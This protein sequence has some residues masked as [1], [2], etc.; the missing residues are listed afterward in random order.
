[1]EISPDGTIQALLQ[2]PGVFMI[3]EKSPLGTQEPSADS[4]VADGESRAELSGMSWSKPGLGEGGE[5][6]MRNHRGESVSVGLGPWEERQW[7]IPS[8]AVGFIRIV[9]QAWSCALISSVL[10]VFVA[11]A[12]G[13]RGPSNLYRVLIVVGNEQGP[14]GGWGWENLMDNGGFFQISAS[15]ELFKFRSAGEKKR[16][17]VKIELKRIFLP[18][19]A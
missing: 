5:V 12:R 11:V 8:W 19:S 10:F 18:T 3:L 1:M 15:Q 16:G 13:C 6:E 7:G 14:A 9:E 17:Y 2:L 4:L